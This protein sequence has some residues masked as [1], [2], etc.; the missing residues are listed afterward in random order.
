MLGYLK[1]RIV[2]DKIQTNIIRS[3]WEPPGRCRSTVFCSIK[4]DS[5][6]TF[7]TWGPI[8]HF[9]IKLIS[10]PLKDHLG[11]LSL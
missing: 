2:A 10:G 4:L 9:N 5:L 1:M 6:V 8:Y 7:L 11:L 3:L